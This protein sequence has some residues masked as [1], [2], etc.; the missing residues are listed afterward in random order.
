MNFGRQ[1]TRAGKMRGT[2]LFFNAEQTEAFIWTENEEIA[3]AVIRREDFQQVWPLLAIG[4]S[5]EFQSY[6]FAAMHFI[7]RI[8]EI[9]GKAMNISA[10]ILRQQS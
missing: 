1:K 10:G 9:D 3:L 7:D 5:V 2:L 8:T 6:A 4:I